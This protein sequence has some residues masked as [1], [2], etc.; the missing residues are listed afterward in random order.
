MLVT[1]EAGGAGP[2]SPLAALCFPGAC[3]LLGLALREAKYS[4]SKTDTC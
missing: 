2:R 3:L 1:G 4:F